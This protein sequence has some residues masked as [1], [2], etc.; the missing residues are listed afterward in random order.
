MAEHAE[1]T[2]L[3]PNMYVAGQLLDTDIGR[4]RE[5]GI[6]V[7]V[8]N[9]PDGEADQIPSTKMSELARAAGMEFAYLPMSNPEDTA[10]QEPVFREILKNNVKVL[11]YCR[12]GRRSS[13]LWQAA[14]SK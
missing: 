6:Q 2:Q 4:I 12:T 11:A 13:A 1:I 10:E 14:T 8:C 7:L 9:R 3:A 5:L